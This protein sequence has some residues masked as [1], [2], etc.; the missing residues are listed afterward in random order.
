MDITGFAWPTDIVDV[1]EITLENGSA[2]GDLSVEDDSF[3]LQALMWG[4][5]VGQIALCFTGW[6]SVTSRASE[7]WQYLWSFGMMYV[8][9]TFLS[10]VT[11][12]SYV[13][14]WQDA[15]L[16]SYN[17]LTFGAL[18][19]TV[20]QVVGDIVGTPLSEISP[21]ARS[22]LEMGTELVAITGGLFA[23][24]GHGWFEHD[25]L[26]HLPIAIIGVIHTINAVMDERYQ[27]NGKLSR[28][29][30]I[31]A[32]ASSY[33]GYTLLKAYQSGG[34]S[35]AMCMV[36]QLCAIHTVY[37]VSID[38]VCSAGAGLS[39]NNIPLIPRVSDDNTKGPT[40]G[41]AGQELKNSAQEKVEKVALGFSNP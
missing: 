7:M 29:D 34:T 11:D 27:A 17:I 6:T 31:G 1:A 30:R 12:D 2:V 40:S 28:V 21:I 25:I 16:T 5:V 20:P 9:T 33:L 41:S 8:M 13:E 10:G 39:D 4:S 18:Y 35:V 3:P 23:I 26:Q 32:A 37:V 19:A 15:R 36:A 14:Q 38:R 24:N 22:A